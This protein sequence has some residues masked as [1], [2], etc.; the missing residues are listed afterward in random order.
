[1]QGLR[2]RPAATA[3][4]FEVLVASTYLRGRWVEGQRER[5]ERGREREIEIE[6]ELEIEMAIG[7]N[8]LTQNQQVSIGQWQYPGGADI[9]PRN[10]DRSGHK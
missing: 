7:E 5:E 10:P 8:A 4:W 3:S 1:M 2:S 6:I 9:L